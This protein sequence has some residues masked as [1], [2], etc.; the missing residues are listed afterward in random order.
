MY[1]L[2]K[3]I[4]AGLMVATLGVGGCAS[5]PD[6]RPLTD[7][8]KN[9]VDDGM[10]Y[11]SA[12]SSAENAPNIYRDQWIT[13]E[14]GNRVYTMNTHEGLGRGYYVGDIRYLPSPRDPDREPLYY[15]RWGNP[16]FDF[17]HNPRSYGNPYGYGHRAYPSRPVIVPA[18]RPRAPSQG[19]ATSPAPVAAP[20]PSRTRDYRQM[21]TPRRQSRSPNSVRKNND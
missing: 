20:A 18:Q 5:S 13:D 2:T 1:R 12:A 8:E 7:L 21:D 19:G 9:F 3:V 6:P 16:V 14:H 10:D 4:F 17:N 11:Y 15:D